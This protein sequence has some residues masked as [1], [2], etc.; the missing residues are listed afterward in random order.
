MQNW[1]LNLFTYNDGDID[2]A[3]DN[4]IEAAIVVILMLDS[5]NDTLLERNSEVIEPA[6]VAS[7][8][9]EPFSSPRTLGVIE[10]NTASQW[11]GKLN[12]SL[13]FSINVVS[14]RGLGVK[15]RLGVTW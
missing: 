12:R 11:G 4:H 3:S 6:G 2:R 15:K 1:G 10:P 9:S 7:A 8:L 14:L 5:D 13:L